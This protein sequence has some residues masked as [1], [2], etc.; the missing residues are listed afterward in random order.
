MLGLSVVRQ[1]HSRIYPIAGF[2]PRY[3]R[4]CSFGDQPW[5]ADGGPIGPKE[6]AT[7][8]AKFQEGGAGAPVHLVEVDIRSGGQVIVIRDHLNRPHPAQKWS[9]SALTSMAAPPGRAAEIT[10]TDSP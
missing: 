2:G 10:T 7:V 4:R 3:R 9:V 1:S 5:G 6:S 8:A